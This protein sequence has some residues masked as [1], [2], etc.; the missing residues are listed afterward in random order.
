MVGYKSWSEMTRAEKRQG[1]LGWAI[2]LAIG[3]VAWLVLHDSE[4][5][6]EPKA[7]AQAEP[8]PPPVAPPKREPLDMS[9]A[10]DL[11]E[12]T[13]KT[14]DEAYQSLLDAMA[15]RDE[16]GKTRYVDQP[17]RNV[18]GRWPTMMDERDATDYF[19]HCGYAAVRLLTL[20]A[21]AMQE[22]NTA[23]LKFIRET[24]A[25]YH[26][27]RARCAEEVATSDQEFR[28][29]DAAEAAELKRRTGGGREC[30]ISYDLDEKG[31]LMTLP[32]PAHCRD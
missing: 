26:K 18:S 15:T 24:E 11:A 16:V 14:M 2:I 3:A 31:N 30:L 28:R 21:G 20:S 10:R 6:A 27:V 17:L 4:P 1:F 8:A 23:G 12:I 7:Q 29:R 5:A 19:G 13:L 32:R 9:V 22:M 25:D